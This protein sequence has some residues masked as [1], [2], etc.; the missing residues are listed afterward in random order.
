MSSPAEISLEMMKIA[1]PGILVII[2][3]YVVLKNQSD[4]NLEKVRLELRKTNASTFN[5]MRMQ[6][7]ERYI[8]FL[9]R[10]TLNHLITEYNRAESNALIFRHAMLETINQEFSHNVAQQ[11]YVSPQAYTIIKVAKEELL[12][13]IQEKS[14]LVDPK[15]PA[16][17]LA[18]ILIEA[19]QEKGQ[20]PVDKAIAFIKSEVKLTFQ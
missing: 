14:K 5:P 13:L 11:I 6:A 16:S 20:Q 10:I 12:Q 4:A 18:K 1:I 17:E 19:V 2:T 3:A 15:G 8:L 7:Y 9:E